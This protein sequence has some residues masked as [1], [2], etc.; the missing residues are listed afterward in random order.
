MQTCTDNVYIYPAAEHTV[1]IKY[2]SQQEAGGIP[3]SVFLLSYFSRR[4]PPCFYKSLKISSLET[5]RTLIIKPKRLLLCTLNIYVCDGG[6]LVCGLSTS[7]RWLVKTHVLYC[8]SQFKWKEGSLVSQHTLCE[9]SIKK[10]WH[11]VKVWSRNKGHRIPSEYQLNSCKLFIYYCMISA[12]HYWLLCSA[13][14][15]TITWLADIQIFYLKLLLWLFL[16]TGL[17]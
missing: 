2:S 15:L 16:A 6:C 5:E 4:H 10:K 3:W 14:S 17:T 9:I 12:V 8:N 11:G 13:A 7:R 1:G